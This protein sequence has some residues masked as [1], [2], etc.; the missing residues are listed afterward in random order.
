MTE[1]PSTAPSWRV[2]SCD[3]VPGFSPS[4]GRYVAQLSETRQELLRY[5][6][7]LSPEQL[8]W[9]PDDQTE[10][11]G[12][13]LLHVAAIEWSWVFEE[14]FQRSSDEYDGWEEALPLRVGLPQVE[15]KSLPYFVDRLDRVRDEILAALGGLTDDDLSRTVASPQEPGAE[16]PS[17]VYTIDWVL[18]H[19]VHHEAHHAGQIELLVRLLPDFAA[20]SKAPAC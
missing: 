14:I 15:G 8:S 12:T 16:S 11:I 1:Y 13:Q 20:S 2:V 3:P 17:E 18:F 5:T 10:S 4:V 7:N 9:H 19:L 6:P